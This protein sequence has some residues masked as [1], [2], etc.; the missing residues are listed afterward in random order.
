[1][2]LI[3]KPIDFSGITG[4]CHACGKKLPKKLAYWCGVRCYGKLQD[5]FY[6]K[7]LKEVEK[8]WDA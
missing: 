8:K 5:K 7:M 1:M 6:K 3:T 2:A 4:K